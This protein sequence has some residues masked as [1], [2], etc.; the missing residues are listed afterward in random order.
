[1]IRCI[2]VLIVSIH[3]AR[4]AT[5]IVP[6]LSYGDV[7]TAL[8]NANH[9]D[10]I[11]LPAGTAVWEPTGPIYCDKGI[12]FQGQGIGVTTIIL[13]NST[14]RFFIFGS[15]GTNR[16]EIS[17]MTLD[18]ASIKA[19]FG[20]LSIGKS[21]VISTSSNLNYRVHDIH[22][23]NTGQRML[24]HFGWTQ[25]VAYS[26]QFDA[27]TNDRPQPVTFYGLLRFADDR[28]NANPFATTFGT[29]TNFPYVEDCGWNYTAGGG[30]GALDGYADARFVIRY[31]NFTN[32]SAPYSVHEQEGSRYATVTEYYMNYWNGSGGGVSALSHLRSGVT[33]IFSNLA[34]TVDY[35]LDRPQPFLSYYAASGTNVFVSYYTNTPRVSVD[36]CRVWDGNTNSIAIGYPAMDQPGWGD[37]STFTGT[38]SMQTFYGSYSW[39]NTYNDQMGGAVAVN[40]TVQDFGGNAGLTNCFGGALPEP[41]DL[42]VEDRDYFNDTPRPDYEPAPYPHLY[43]ADETPFISLSST[44]ATINADTLR[45]TIIRRQ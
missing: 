31:N 30:D 14:Q 43:R 44:T 9:G 4:S 2:L 17:H 29:I 6:S 16:L 26:C 39:G 18:S 35:T 36:G 22:F 42:I 3:V 40:F 45:P 38:N 13:S 21:Q 27:E 15:P 7:G 8:T 10:I 34:E 12:L 24:S 33:T 28:T 11:L 32:A 5:T 1:M 41:S 23:K 20:L 25:G 37:P 19:P